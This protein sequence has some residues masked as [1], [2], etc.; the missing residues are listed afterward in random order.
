[1]LYRLSDI[2]LWIAIFLAVPIGHLRNLQR[3]S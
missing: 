1:M 3:R 2:Y